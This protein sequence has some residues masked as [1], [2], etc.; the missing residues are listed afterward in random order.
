[1]KKVLLGMSGGIDSTWACRVLQKKGYEVEGVVLLLHPDAPLEKAKSAAEKLG[2]KLHVADYSDSFKKEVEEYFV[3]E[4]VS[5]RT[6][7]PCVVCNRKIKFE[8]LINVADSL[9]I[10][11]IA[12][13]HYVKVEKHLGRFTVVSGEDTKK[14][15]SYFLW[16][17]SQEQLSRFIAPLGDAVKSDVINSV[18]ESQLVEEISES[19]E[20]CFIPNDDYISYLKEHLDE[21][22]MKTAFTKGNFVDAQGNVL[23]KHN[24]IAS[25]TVGQRKGLGIALGKPA[26]V[27]EIRPETNEVVLGFE[28]DNSSKFFKV[29][30][31]NFMGMEETRGRVS[32]FVRPRYRSPLIPCT[33]DI[34]ENSAEVVPDT[35][36][37]KP[38]SGQSAVFY[39]E[40]GRILFGGYI[41]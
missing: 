23:G 15:Q 6:P 38:S 12:T 9:G 33:V 11:L 17:L 7:N 36:I 27:T 39:D 40:E 21:D 5:G 26:Y 8:S 16:Q 29:R 24:G 31:L 2:I 28:E 41:V 4:Y 14:D 37:K 13:G 3:K 1:M 20:I 18:K 34:F 10:D 25:Y 35:L 19:Q 30:S 22:G 32:C